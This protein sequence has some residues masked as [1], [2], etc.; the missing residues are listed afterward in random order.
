MYRIVIEIDPISIAEY[1][2]S[3]DF[4]RWHGLVTMEA[5]KD[6]RYIFKRELKISV[7]FALFA[8]VVD[9]CFFVVLVFVFV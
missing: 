7:A 2:W 9:A 8:F 5:I 4:I 1:C 6:Y 3:H